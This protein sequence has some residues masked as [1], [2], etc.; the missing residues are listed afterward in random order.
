MAREPELSKNGVRIPDECGDRSKRKPGGREIA[1]V[2]IGVTLT[3]TFKRGGQEPLIKSP[4]TEAGSKKQDVRRG[5]RLPS[6]PA[7]SRSRAKLMQT[8]LAMLHIAVAP[9]SSPA[10]LAAMRTSPLQRMSP[11]FVR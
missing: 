7:R 9:V 5:R 2:S 3:Q 1:L 6:T 8:H 11:G 4:K 10:R